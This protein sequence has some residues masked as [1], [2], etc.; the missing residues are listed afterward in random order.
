MKKRLLALG[1]TLCLM[2]TLAAGCGNSSENE[3]AEDTTNTETEK[4]ALRVATSPTFPPTSYNDDDGNLAGFEYEV[5]EEIGKRIGRDVEWTIAEGTDNLFGTLDAGKVDT[6]AF[7]ISINEE[8]KENYTFSDVYGTN[9]IFLAVREDFTYDTLD[10]LQGK[11]VCL[12][13]S[14]SLYPILEGYN[15]S[16]SE[17]QQI[18]LVPAESSN[19][20]EDLEMGRIDAFPITEIGFATAMEKQD[21]KIKLGGEALV[22]EENAYPFAKDADEELISEVNEA[23]QEMLNDGTLAEISEKNY[24]MDVTPKS[25]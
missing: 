9:Q 16:L 14:H 5:I 7:Q 4:S 24:K 1:L 21:Y 25:E 17:D 19:I 23:I 13:P 10:D 22:I 8:R 3:K 12:N 15:S 18:K 6:I 20:Y 11:T 2:G